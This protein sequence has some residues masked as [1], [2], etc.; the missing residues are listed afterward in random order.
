MAKINAYKIPRGWVELI[1]GPM[2]SG[3]TD[4][5]WRKLN[6]LNYADIQ[7]IIFMPRIDTRTK[8]E[9]VS[10][11][12]HRMKS[13]TVA[14]STDIIS[15]LKKIKNKVHYVAIDEAQFFDEDLPDVCQYLADNR[16]N[17]F[18]AG[19]D[20]DFRG[21]P[22]E[23]IT[24]IMGIAEKIIKLNAICTVCGAPATRTQR[25]INGKPAD[26][27][28]PI[29]KIGNYESYEARCRVHHIVTNK[30]KYKFKP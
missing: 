30:P 5:L 24:K 28:D 17:V 19:L 10:R 26:Y 8:Q 9:I 23:V 21:V 2:F 20:T 29:V 27:F 11:D 16:F 4:E 6:R 12:N 15:Y 18:V 1:C 13:I 3:K 14:K 7:Y 22:F 25:I